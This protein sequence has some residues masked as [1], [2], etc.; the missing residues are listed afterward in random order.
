V[1]SCAD[2][3]DDLALLAALRRA[4]AF[5]QPKRTGDSLDRFVWVL[6]FLIV[7]F[8]T[9]FLPSVFFSKR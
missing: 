2:C 7:L 8:T 9:G 5:L 1:F 3:I 4:A 6:V